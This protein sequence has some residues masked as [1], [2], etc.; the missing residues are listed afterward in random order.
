[1]SND[2][3]IST[4]DNSFAIT[5]SPSTQMVLHESVIIIPISTTAQLKLNYY[6]FNTINGST[7][8]TLALTDLLSIESYLSVNCFKGT[9]GANTSATEITQTAN[10]VKLDNILTELKGDKFLTETI[11][12]DKTDITKFYIRKT[13]LNQDT[14]VITISF[15]NIDGTTASPIVTNLVSAVTNRAIEIIS[16]EYDVISNGTGYSIGDQVEELKLVNTADN[17]ITI[18]YYNKTLGTTISPIFSSLQLLGKYVTPSHVELLSSLS[19]TL[20]A[21]I[22]KSISMV[23]MDGSCNIT[24]DGVLINN[25]PTNYSEVWGNGISILNKVITISTNAT[26]RVIINLIK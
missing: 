1:M 4:V 25:F 26:S 21:N 9:S 5:V 7:I 11:W 10:G 18:L 23:V 6:E 14:G 3:L 22:Y 8:A 15:L 20:P 16:T 17:T 12:Y 13:S 2:V 24:V 19:S